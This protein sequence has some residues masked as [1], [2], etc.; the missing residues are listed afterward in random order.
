[1]QLA[2]L[3]DAWTRF[4]GSQV[5]GLVI[6]RRT[7]DYRRRPSDRWLQIETPIES[8]LISDNYLGE[9]MAQ[10]HFAEAAPLVADVNDSMIL[11][12]AGGW[13][14]QGRFAQA[15]H[16]MVVMMC[17]VMTGNGL[18]AEGVSFAPAPPRQMGLPAQR[19]G[20]QK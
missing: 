16:R 13:T 4:E 18:P 12:M 14:C 8:V 9:F 17:P 6:R 7:L 5:E 19:G 11:R 15:D 1:M 10:V 3:G 20:W 2:L